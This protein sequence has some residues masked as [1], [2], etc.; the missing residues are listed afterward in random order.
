MSEEA[1]WLP[2]PKLK[3]SP[4]HQLAER[5]SHKVRRRVG[6]PHLEGRCPY[7]ATTAEN[8]SGRSCLNRY[9]TIPRTRRR[10]LRTPGNGA[11]RRTDRLL[12]DARIGVVL[13]RR[14]VR[15]QPL[16]AGRMLRSPRATEQP[17]AFSQSEHCNAVVDATQRT[18]LPGRE[19][20]H[21]PNPTPD[22]ASTRVFI[23]PASVHTLTATR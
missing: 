23:I 12:H 22:A 20:S 5:K 21:P 2:P 14:K 4:V 3:L 15:A 17:L 6:L 9:S 7:L 8:V 1:R 18:D 16:E 13:I 10:V 11:D 19:L